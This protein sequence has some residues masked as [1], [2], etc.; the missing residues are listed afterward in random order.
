[1]SVCKSCKV[2]KLPVSFKPWMYLCDSCFLSEQGVTYEEYYKWLYKSP[3]NSP[4]PDCKVPT[5]TSPYRG[6][7]EQ[8]KI[9][10]EVV[11]DRIPSIGL[12]N[13]LTHHIDHKISSAAGFILG[14]SPEDISHL[15]NL[16]I[17]TASDNKRKGMV[18]F[19]DDTNRWILVKYRL[20][21]ESLKL[22]PN[23]LKRFNKVV[24]K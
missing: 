13:Y 10:T 5:K 14:I 1:M 15:S 21:E 24:S 16:R 9:L 12:R 18:S 4:V 23:D 17:I 11:K 2:S 8:V 3:T 22:T 6:Y 19:V 20:T 7:R